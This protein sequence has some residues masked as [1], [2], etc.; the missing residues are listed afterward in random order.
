VALRG[1]L[2]GLAARVLGASLVAAAC[3]MVACIA[4]QVVMRY[5]FGRTPSWSSATASS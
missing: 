2:V 5:V 4:I 3:V 1:R